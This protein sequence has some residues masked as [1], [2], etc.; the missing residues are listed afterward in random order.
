M[1]RWL[2]VAALLLILPVVAGQSDAR[3]PEVTFHQF[4]RIDFA[5]ADFTS[6]CEI[7]GVVVS[8]M[9]T[10]FRFVEGRTP[11]DQDPLNDDLRGSIG[12]GCGTMRARLNV[13]PTADHVVVR[14]Q[15]DRERGDA[16]NG[17]EDAS[18]I[19]DLVLRDRDVKEIQSRA[20][21]E[22][23]TPSAEAT[24]IEIP[25][26][27][28]LG[29]SIYVDWVFADPGTTQQSPQSTSLSGN[30]FRAGVDDAVVEAIG[31]AL[32]SLVTAQVDDV[33]FGTQLRTQT[34]VAVRL[35][36]FSQE[37]PAISIRVGPAL[38]L[39]RV[40]AP[41]GTDLGAPATFDG[42]VLGLDHEGVVVVLSAANSQVVVP[43]SL[44]E[45]HGAGQ[46]MF[47][48][49]ENQ[50]LVVS[51]ALVPFSVVLLAT[52]LPFAVLAWVESRA[53]RRE[54]F[55]GY[56]RSARNLQYA[57]TLVLLYYVAVVAS[58]AVGGRLDLMAL[59]PLP[60]EGVLLYIQLGVAGIAFIALWLVAR[61]LYMLVKPRPELD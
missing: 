8:P 20:V 21:F 44:V 24:A 18:L 23:R 12:F 22:P 5:Q 6:T 48:F 4:H 32:P 43:Q 60:L 38:N 7:G 25:F 17:A 13:L 39:V 49:E 36:Q 26:N 51:P 15:A 35:P 33:R 58:A 1:K 47:V 9:G 10:G 34:Q 31:D 37:A 30:N 3:T 28:K 11:N 16:G 52:P 40:T 29:G 41:D 57:V 19:Q 59:L 55:G 14:F 42:G 46:Y 53:F 2:V 45:V 27:G 56:A 54:A 50:G 61:E